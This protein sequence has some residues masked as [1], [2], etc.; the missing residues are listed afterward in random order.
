ME[1]VVSS[2]F[3]ATDLL[4]TNY[5]VSSSI[6]EFVRL[7]EIIEFDGEVA[8]FV[9]HDREIFTIYLNTAEFAFVIKS[10]RKFSRLDFS[11][12]ITYIIT[13]L[14]CICDYIR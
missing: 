5:Y 9:L 12:Y 3:S 14:Q 6:I 1:Y 10:V 13:Y 4:R 11:Y 8:N 2:R 7:P